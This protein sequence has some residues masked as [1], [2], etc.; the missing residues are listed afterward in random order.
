[1]QVF[2]QAAA[3]G[4]GRPI[5][6]VFSGSEAQLSPAGGAVSEARNSV[7]ET[8]TGACLEVEVSWSAKA[9]PELPRAASTT[10][11]RTM[12]HLFMLSSFQERASAQPR[13]YQQLFVMLSAEVLRGS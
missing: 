3:K 11:S 12:A 9:K 10:S 8:V 5:S 7:A 4:A 6:E 1:V 13:F 2:V